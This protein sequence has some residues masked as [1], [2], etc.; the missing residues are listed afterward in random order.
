MTPVDG[1][2]GGGVLL[3][4][5]VCVVIYLVG[6]IWFPDDAYERGYNDACDDWRDDG[7]GK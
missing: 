1:F 6:E 2:I 7:R 5:G 4:W 3:G